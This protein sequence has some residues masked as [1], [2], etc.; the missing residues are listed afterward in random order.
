MDKNNNNDNEY[1]THNI[2]CSDTNW[3]PVIINED[4]NTKIE[5]VHTDTR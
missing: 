5:N 3:V 1:E 2:D 4:T